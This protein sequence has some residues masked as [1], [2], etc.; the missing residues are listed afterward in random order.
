VFSAKAYDR[1]FLDKA[2]SAGHQELRY[3]ESRLTAATSSISEGAA[4][5]CL[6][7]NDHADADAIDRLARSGIKLIALRAAGFDNVDLCAART[8]GI[9]VCRVPAYSPNAVAEHAFA[10]ILS[11][12]RK[13][14]R[15]YDR[16]REGNFSLDGLLGFDL[17]GK[18][19]GIVGVGKIGSVV[20]RIARG[21]GCDV[22]GSDPFP[23]DVVGVRFC[24]L[25]VLLTV[26]DI[27]TLHCPLSETTRHLINQDALDRLKAG[28]ILVNT[29]RGAVI[30]TPAVISALEGNRLGGLA[31]DVYEKEANLFFED[32]SGQPMF[33]DQFA[34]LLSFPNVL[35]TGHQGFFTAEALTNIADTTIANLDAFERT[36]APLFPVTAALAAQPA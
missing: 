15:A 10:L 5:V 20:A 16:I 7:A 11:L 13:T 36:G 22:I 34:R 8:H 32:H 19:I 3:I 9:T 2:N 33:D 4:A 30:D 21:F 29:S 26:S 25:D 17:A 12:V 27:V 23:S 18:T 24:A 31:I 35:V 14:H 6:F 1:T 28:A